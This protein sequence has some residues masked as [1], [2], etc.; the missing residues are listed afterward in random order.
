MCK[1]GVGK[2][3]GLYSVTVNL[4]DGF[5]VTRRLPSLPPDPLP[6][7]VEKIGFRMVPK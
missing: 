4:D 2:V 1:V 6:P 5:K 3:S 7:E